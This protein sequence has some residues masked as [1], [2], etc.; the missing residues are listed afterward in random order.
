MNIFKPREE[1]IELSKLRLLHK[2]MILPNKD[3]QNFQ[4]LLKGYEGEVM[5]DSYVEQMSSECIVLNDL[6]YSVNN[7]LLQIDSLVITPENIHL[8]EIKNYEGDYYFESGQIFTMS[9][10][11]IINPLHQL[12]RSKY[13]FSQL[14]LDNGIKAPVIASVVFVHPHFTLY[15]APLDQPFVFPTQIKPY[16]NKMVSPFKR[17]N[18]KH[19]KIAE[20]LCS[21][22]ITE[23]LFSL[24]PEYDFD[25]LKKGITCGKCEAFSV[26]LN[27]QECVCENCGFE[28]SLSE[29]VVRSVKEFTILFPD[30]KITT[31]AI[32]EWCRIIPYKKKIKRILENHFE[33]VGENRWTYFRI[34]NNKT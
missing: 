4:S 8:F 17:L 7:S 33:Q 11:E 24:L 20:K 29:A 18:E 31:T 2:R 28:E 15:Q 34:K 10:T 3:K 22:H 16:L 30:H 32:Y 9:D 19:W 6:L 5:F 21:L 14:L 1:P 13:L 23:S 25:K 26:L 12:S 27:G